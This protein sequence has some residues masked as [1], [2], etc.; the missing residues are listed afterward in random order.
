MAYQSPLQKK[1]NNTTLVKKFLR[2]MSGKEPE[3][4]LQGFGAKGVDERLDIA[5][6]KALK[7]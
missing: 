3:L 5:L 2:M 1:G 6:E 4:L 7:W